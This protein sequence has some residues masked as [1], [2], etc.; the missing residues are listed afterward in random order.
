MLGKKVYFITKYSSVNITQKCSIILSPEFYWVISKHLPV[1]TV[2]QAKKLCNSLFDG[3]LPSGNYQY[4]VVKKGDIFLLFAYDSA[5]ILNSLQK[6][7][8]NVDLI[9][10]I[11]FAQNELLCDNAYEIDEK[12]LICKD[13]IFTILPKKLLHVET[14]K[15]DELSFEKLSNIKISIDKYNLFLDKKVYNFLMIAL[16]LFI[17]LDIIEAFVYKI[18]LDKSAKLRDNIYKKYNLPSTSWQINA[19]RKSLI[20]KH[21]SQIALRKNIGKILN[22]KL[23]SGEYFEEID[24]DAKNIKFTLYMQNDKRAEDIKDK[25]MKNF[26]VLRAVVKDKRLRMELNNAKN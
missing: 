24:S 3:I 21:D 8:L 25:L 10:N 7:G 2:F 22:L 26:N 19:I 5:Y 6:I 16:M 11:Y 20:S 14:K 17:S 23:K 18:S 4:K 15:I 1:K 9:S 12:V 13:D